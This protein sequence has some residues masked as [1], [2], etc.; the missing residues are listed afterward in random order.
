MLVN[1]EST[2]LPC[3][4][5][6]LVISRRY[7]PE[8]LSW[9]PRFLSCLPLVD[10]HTTTRVNLLKCKPNHGTFWLKSL[11]RLHFIQ[12]KSRSLYTAL[13]ALHCPGCLYLPD[14]VTSGPAWSLGSGHTGFSV[15]QTAGMLPPQGLCTGHSLFPER[16][17]PRRGVCGSL[18]PQVFSPSERG[19]LDH[20]I[21]DR[22][23]FL[24]L[25]FPPHPPLFP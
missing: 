12:R 21:H 8:S 7:L 2:R 6:A 23:P 25:H 4:V 5:G 14:S 22:H 10:F 15:P 11:H 18:N 3:E 19:H 20:R 13:K 1:T 17:S 24:T 9:P 16:S